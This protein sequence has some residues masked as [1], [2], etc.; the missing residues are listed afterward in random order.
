MHSVDT[1]SYIQGEEVRFK[2][3]HFWCESPYI[4]RPMV[5]RVGAGLGKSWSEAKLGP[6]RE[7]L[8][9]GSSLN[10]SLAAD[11]NYERTTSDE[12]L[13][14]HSAEGRER[15]KDPLI[16]PLEWHEHLPNR[17]RQ[18]RPQDK[19]LLR[20]TQGEASR[21][22]S[23]MNQSYFLPPAA[24]A[25][26]NR[27]RKPKLLSATA[28]EADPVVRGKDELNYRTVTAD[29]SASAAL[30]FPARQSHQLRLHRNLSLPTTAVSELLTP[31]GQIAPIIPRA[32]KI[33]AAE[34]VQ[35]SLPL[36]VRRGRPS[37]TGR[38]LSSTMEWS[39]AG[40]PRVGTP[41]K[42][43]GLEEARTTAA[44][45]VHAMEREEGDGMGDGIGGGHGGGMDYGYGSSLEELPHFST[46]YGSSFALEPPPLFV[47]PLSPASRRRA[48]EPWENVNTDEAWV[49]RKSPDLLARR[50]LRAET[51]AYD[52]RFRKSAMPIAVSAFASH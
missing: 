30:T 5:Q 12:R 34:R 33:A 49:P 1:I 37:S 23:M 16:E 22:A 35:R 32:W 14:L 46:S 20:V 28:A 21:L 36:T 45:R 9:I 52:R 43:A 51:R 40:A 24:S 4:H 26:R 7:P 15:P 31:D 2:G 18:W 29:T 6:T 39:G 44:H 8:G 10:A 13:Q 11:R 19:R 48:V 42:E 17:M 38:S 41:D 3:T 25:V 47:P 50:K 27:N